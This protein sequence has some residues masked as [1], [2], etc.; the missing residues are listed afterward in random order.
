MPHSRAQALTPEKELLLLCARTRFNAEQQQRLAELTSRQLDWDYILREASENSITPLLARSLQEYTQQIPA[1]AREQLVMAC[2][3]NTVRCLLLSSELLRILSE[4]ESHGI[5]AIPYKGPVTAAQAYGEFTLREFEDLDIIISQRDMPRAN[6]RMQAMGYRPKFDWIF[7]EGAS[8]ALVPGEYNYRDEARGTMVELH[9]ELTMR[10]CPVPP[11][12]RKM[13]TRLVPVSVNGKELHTFRPEEALVMLCIHGSK[14][15]WERLSWIA[16]IAELVQRHPTINWDSVWL[17]AEQLQAVR[18][19]RVALLLCTDLLDAPLADEMLRPARADRI[20]AQLAA[21]MED[22]LLQ[23]ELPPLD[24]PARFHL[25]RRMVIDKRAGWRYA[26]RLSSVPAEE[27]WLM[28]RLPP[29]LA[30]LYIV[31]R[32]LRLLRKYGWSRR[33]RG[34]VVQS[35]QQPARG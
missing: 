21:Q 16:D 12:V 9:T 6:E 14:D 4:F 7:S 26:I 1:G 11:D 31:L 32:P 10:Q 28:I 2:R 19:V 20:A 30:P 33:T 8:A 15:F 23:R 29:R 25:R 18:M 34:D 24:A 17:T 27:D 35:P 3:A 22:R 13:A 5:V